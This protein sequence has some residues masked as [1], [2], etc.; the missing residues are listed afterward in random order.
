MNP[1][2]Q[3]RIDVL[4]RREGSLTVA[5]ASALL[6]TSERTAWRLARRFAT[7][8]V[9]GIVHG[10]RGRASPRRLP[11]TGSA[12][13]SSAKGRYRG[14][15]DSHLGELLAEAEDI[16]IGRSTLQR[17]LRRG[18]RR[19]H[20]AA[21][22]SQVSKPRERMPQAGLVQIDGSPDHRLEG[23]GPRLTLV[24]AI[25]DATGTIVAATF[26][27][28]EDGRAYLTILA[29]MCSDHGVQRP[30]RDRGHGLA[31]GAACRDLARICAFRWR[32]VVGND[33]TV[34]VEGAVLQLPATHGGRGLA[35]RRV[36]VELRLDGR[37][38]SLT[39]DAPCSPCRSHPIPTI[40][41]AC[42]SSPRPVGRRHRAVRSEPYPPRPT[43][44]EAARTQGP[45]PDTTDRISEQL[46]YR[47]TVA[48]T[49]TDKCL[50][51][52]GPTVRVRERSS[53]GPR[54][55]SP[56]TR[57]RSRLEPVPDAQ[58]RPDPPR[59]RRIELELETKSADVLRHGLPPW[60]PGPGAPQ[61][62]SSRSLLVKTR[63]GCRARHSSS[64]NSVGVRTTDRPAATMSRVP[65]S[66]TR[67]SYE[68][69]RDGER[70]LAAE[71]G[72]DARGQLGGRE[73]CDDVVV[74]STIES[75]HALLRCAARRED[76]HGDHGLLADPPESLEPR[77][78]W[79]AGVEDDQIRRDLVDQPEGDPTIGGFGDDHSIGRA[80][81]R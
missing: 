14:V 53:C 9:E 50:Y 18:G 20:P 63:R 16:V 74:G 47:I 73:R 8:G 43:T 62:S 7:L 40:C 54:A 67:S 66:I 25:D 28:A 75:D 69:L 78:P 45:E 58:H 64:A 10:N 36:E 19:G 24:G 49:R 33:N 3:Q 59:S 29:R 11:G 26:A 71:D 51:S 13:S 56:R 2:D 76:D 34:R 32:R 55:W 65:E 57:A 72:S 79:Q 80:A 77:H 6:G 5:E 23:R 21:T 30:A 81:A 48:T 61:T 39:M 12:S 41:A 68:L 1:R 4:A 17:L 35:G 15:N 27:E 31:T 37:S 46:N 22:R 60:N 42:S 44:P 38:S 70:L 52:F